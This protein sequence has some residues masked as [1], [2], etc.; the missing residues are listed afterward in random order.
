MDIKLSVLI[1]S[2]PERLSH[3]ARMISELERQATQLPVE[4]LV[5]IDNKKRTTGSKRNILIEQAQ[6]KYV[7]FVDDDDRIEPD[8]IQTLV[9]T[10]DQNP[11]ADCI[12]FDV[13]VNLSGLEKKITKYDVNYLHSQDNQYYYRKPNHIMCYAKRIAIQENFLNVSY[14]E[15]DEWAARA[16]RLIKNQIKIPRVLYY[17]DYLLKRPKNNPSL[18]EWENQLMQN[19]I[20]EPIDPI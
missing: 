15:D 1:P 12:T 9:E 4:I 6:G 11:D 14:G 5:I 20:E 10:I 17:Y 8:Y 18:R 2:T 7:S 3:L 19:A 13:A 16:S